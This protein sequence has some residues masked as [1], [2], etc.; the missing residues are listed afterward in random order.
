[1][2]VD[3]ARLTKRSHDKPQTQRDSLTSFDSCCEIPISQTVRVVPTCGCEY[4]ILLAN[5]SKIRI[6]ELRTL[7]RN[8]QRSFRSMP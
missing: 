1:M 3:F 4:G 6:Q 8:K 7:G 2:I 5:G